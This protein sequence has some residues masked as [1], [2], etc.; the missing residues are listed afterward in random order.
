MRLID[1]VGIRW[2]PHEMMILS[3]SAELEEMLH[4]FLSALQV[5]QK[6]D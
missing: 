2:L 6:R 3:V 1:Y 5:M 4:S